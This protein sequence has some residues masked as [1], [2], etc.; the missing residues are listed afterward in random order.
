ML[1][2]TR[3]FYALMLKYMKLAHLYFN[4]LFLHT[5]TQILSFP[6]TIQQNAGSRASFVR[7]L[8]CKVPQAFNSF[9]RLGCCGS[10]LISTP[11]FHLQLIVNRFTARCLLPIQ[12]FLYSTAAQVYHSHVFSVPIDLIVSMLHESDS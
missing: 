9:C 7:Y 10:D 3:D 5:C 1:I 6:K 12:V 11:H 8:P 2:R 4:I